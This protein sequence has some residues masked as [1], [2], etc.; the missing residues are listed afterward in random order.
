VPAARRSLAANSGF[1]SG[2]DADPTGTN[3][4]PDDDEDN[5][6]EELSAYDRD[7]SGHHKNHRKNPQESC[8]V[9]GPFASNGCDGDVAAEEVPVRTSTMTMQEKSASC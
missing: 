1:G 6:P 2:E 5:S 7:N 4:E 8:H 9:Y 3:E